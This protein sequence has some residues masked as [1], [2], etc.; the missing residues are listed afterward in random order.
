MGGSPPIPFQYLIGGGARRRQARVLWRSNG[1]KGR[2]GCTLTHLANVLAGAF[3]GPCGFGNHIA[4]PT[5][6]IQEGA[7]SQTVAGSKPMAWRATQQP[8]AVPKGWYLKWEKELKTLP[9]VL[10]WLRSAGP[11]SGFLRGHGLW[12]KTTICPDPAAFD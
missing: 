7:W 2:K 5:Y 3:M 12:H 11:S 6:R 4:N 1:S 10:A 8:L 9:L